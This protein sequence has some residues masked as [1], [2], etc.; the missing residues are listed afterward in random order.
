MWF[1]GV[2]C[3]CSLPMVP[4]VPGALLHGCPAFV[5]CAWCLQA[6]PGEAG[7]GASVQ[8]PRAAFKEWGA[9]LLPTLP[10]PAP[11]V[12]LFLTHKPSACLAV[13]VVVWCGHGKHLHTPH[14]ASQPKVA[15]F[16]LAGGAHQHM[17]WPVYQM[18]CRSLGVC[19][20][21]QHWASHWAGAPHVASKW[22][23]GGRA[24]F[25]L[26]SGPA[27]WPVPQAAGG[28]GFSGW[29]PHL[30][31]PHQSGCC[32][33]PHRSQHHSQCTPLAP[34]THLQALRLL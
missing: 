20:H 22:W 32:W 23:K 19:M 6:A 8:L 28:S 29:W 9:T 25:D 12:S 17:G 4:V 14:P 5:W 18:S 2:F 21:K 30:G 27:R 15:R 24:V 33:V 7:C 3:C 34:Q 26:L 16:C 13:G 1:N 11:L 31:T 10:L